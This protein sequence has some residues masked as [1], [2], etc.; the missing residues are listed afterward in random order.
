LIFS[1]FVVWVLATSC[2]TQSEQ[3][4][5][6]PAPKVK[7]GAALKAKSKAPAAPDTAKQQSQQSSVGKGQLAMGTGQPSSFWTEE[8]D[9]DDDGVVETSDFLYDAGRGVLYTDR[10]GDFACANGGAANGGILQALYA[11]GN[12]TGQ[13]VGSG[14]YAVSLNETQ[15][16]AKQ[17]GTYGCRFAADGNPTTCGSA[18]IN[19]DTGEIDVAVAQ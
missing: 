2:S 10:E 4:I 1:L 7:V 5:Q 3:T 9:V 18:T 8:V 14:W 15:C 17:A 16:G 11:D 19:K 6:K 13:P 12:K